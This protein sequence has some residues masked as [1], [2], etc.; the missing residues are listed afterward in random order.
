MD[1]YTAM[2]TGRR[3]RRL[4]SP[5]LGVTLLL[6]VGAGCGA[7]SQSSS[8]TAVAAGAPA[9]APASASAAT[10][11]GP[12]PRTSPSIEQLTTVIAQVKER[13]PMTFQPNASHVVAFG[14]AVC[15]AFD[16]GKSGSQVKGLVLQAASQLPAI[17][18]SAA[19]ATF[20]VGTA[21]NLFCP[22]YSARLAS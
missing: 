19:D 9:S 22:G 21:V 10:A 12:A 20:A 15:T 16:Q 6:V 1:V 11:Q 18:V 3:G 8:G 14:D 4:L 13:I 17:T 2:R 5:A 7:R